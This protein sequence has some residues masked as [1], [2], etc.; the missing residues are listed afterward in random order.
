[1]E[2]VSLDSSSFH[3]FLKA[4]IGG[5][6]ED[7]L[8]DTGA[9]RT[10]FDLSHLVEEPLSEEF[11]LQTAGIGAESL[12]ISFGCLPELLLDNWEIKN[13][14]VAAMDFSRINDWYARFS[15]RRIAA[16]IGSDFLLAHKAKIDYSKRCV[17]F[18]VPLSQ[19]RRPLSDSAVP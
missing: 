18:S 4:T 8:I 1:M 14:K 9:S 5:R 19:I 17:T 15:S 6:L 2:I 10:V 13:L 7:I 11:T 12:P 3:L 16:L